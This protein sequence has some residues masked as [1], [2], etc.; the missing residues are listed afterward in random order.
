M[1]GGRTPETRWAVN[2]RQDNKLENCCIWLAIYLNCTMMHGFTNLKF[3]N[4]MST[5]LHNCRA[6]IQYRNMS[7]SANQHYSLPSKHWCPV[8][9]T[10]YLQ[11]FT[12]KVLTIIL[13]LNYRL[14]DNQSEEFKALINILY[15][16]LQNSFSL[17][18]P[19]H[20]VMVR[21]F[22]RVSTEQPAT[23]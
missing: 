16:N 6:C 15:D 5:I 2:E 13:Q 21:Q 11:P 12:E 23:K 14:S 9:N 4:Y 3:L 17:L 1:T 8:A 10:K 19:W 22:T 18:S 7:N 20:R